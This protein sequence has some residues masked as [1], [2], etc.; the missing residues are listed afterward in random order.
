MYD[1]FRKPNSNIMK[2]LKIYNA[3]NDKFKLFFIHIIENANIFI[4]ILKKVG[5]KLYKTCILARKQN[6]VYIQCRIFMSKLCNLAKKR[7]TSPSG[8][9]VLPYYVPGLMCLILRNT[10]Q[11]D[12]LLLFD[13]HM[14]LNLIMEDRVIYQLPSMSGDLSTEYTH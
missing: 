11:N 4:K 10:G 9:S 8:P 14:I 1:S 3:S 6:A 5:S 12:G 7:H 13:V 2:A